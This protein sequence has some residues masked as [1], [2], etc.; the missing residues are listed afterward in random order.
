M[1]CIYICL[2]KDVKICNK[3]EWDMGA[4]CFY[5]SFLNKCVYSFSNMIKW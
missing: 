1:Y 4:L 3:I 2:E 5:L